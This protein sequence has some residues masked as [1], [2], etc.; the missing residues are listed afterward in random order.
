MAP[1]EPQPDEKGTS[2][3]QATQD[4]PDILNGA[5]GYAIKRAQVHA[6][7]LFY[8]SFGQDTISPARLTALTFISNN[9]G[10]TQSALAQKL[11]ISRAG[12]VKVVDRLEAM[13]LIE[14]RAKK[15]DRRSYSLYLTEPGKDE[16]SWLAK[17]TQK[18][19]TLLASN[20]ND[21]EREQLITLLEKMISPDTQP[22]T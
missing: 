19:E 11:N 16:L 5:L 22:Q 17:Q 7:E 18:Y 2:S 6:Y 20:L 9:A 12:I 14:R 10:I 4:L 21:T 13:N 3:G 8:K 1:R 15:G